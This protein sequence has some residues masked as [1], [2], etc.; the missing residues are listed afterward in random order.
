MPKNPTKTLKDMTQRLYRMQQPLKWQ[1]TIEHCQ[2]HRAETDVF[3][4]G[5]QACYPERLNFHKVAQRIAEDAFVKPL[6]KLMDDPCSSPFFAICKGEIAAQGLQSWSA[7]NP[8]RI[9]RLQPG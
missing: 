3:P 2:R 7:L 5:L 8:D 4:L 6:M 9:A 1:Q